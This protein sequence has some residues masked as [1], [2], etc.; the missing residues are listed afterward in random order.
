MSDT[1]APPVPAADSPRED[2]SHDDPPRE[3]PPDNPFER[4]RSRWLLPCVFGAAMAVFLTLVLATSVI[5]IATGG[6]LADDDATRQILAMLAG[7]GGMIAWLLWACRRAGVDLGRLIGRVP[8]GHDW[9]IT[10]ALLAVTITFSYGSWELV[11][12]ILSRAA[13]DLLNW[14]VQMLP[15][16]PAGNL[17]HDIFT[18]LILVVAAPVVE[19]VLFRGVLFSRWGV[20][21]GVRTGIVVSAVAF[22]VL[23]ANVIGIGFVGLVAAMLYFQTRTLIVPIV[24]HAT[25][26]AIGA[27]GMYLPG[28]SDTAAIIDGDGWLGFL[29]VFVTLPVL[30]WYVWRFWPKSDA[31]I[32][33][34]GGDDP[35]APG[36]ETATVDDPSATADDTAAERPR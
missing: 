33:Y 21:W 3:D 7:Y 14:L 35:S 26:N 31:A 19:E 6:A 15:E 30:I 32:P 28:G 13:P 5:G 25:N 10:G 12:W 20:K 11:A 18:V 29:L 27:I 36:D 24:F 8:A 34:M 17:G 4:V 22:G 23:H 1:G 16:K 9:A 2:P